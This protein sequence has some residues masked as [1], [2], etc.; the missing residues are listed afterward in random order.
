MQSLLGYEQCSKIY[1][2]HCHG[3]Q[4]LRPCMRSTSVDVL[5]CPIMYR[6]ATSGLRKRASER[7][8]KIKERS[9]YIMYNYPFDSQ[10]GLNRPYYLSISLC[11]TPDNFTCQWGNPGSHCSDKIFVPAKQTTKYQLQTEKCFPFFFIHLTIL[12][13]TFTKYNL[14]TCT[15]NN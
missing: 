3:Y 4:H 7:A 10:S 15:V 6:L 9:P 2:G 5:F 11:L 13:G 12:P 14:N 1:Q 8:N